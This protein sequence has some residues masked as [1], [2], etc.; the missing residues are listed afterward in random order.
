MYIINKKVNHKK[1][2]K[3]IV[4]SLDDGRFEIKF[5]NGEI[6]K[7]VYP[8]AFDKHLTFEDKQYQK[9]AE[10]E[11]SAAETARQQH[12]EEIASLVDYNRNGYINPEIG[13][14]PGYHPEFFTRVYPVSCSEV[15]NK[16]DSGIRCSVKGIHP[17][18][19]KIV[20]I[21]SLDK[22]GDK[23]LYKDHWDKK[24]YYIY[25][26][27]G[28]KGD[29]DLTGRNLTLHNCLNTSNK[30]YLYIKYNKQYYYQGVHNLVD[31]SERDGIDKKGN[32]RKEYNFKLE[33]ISA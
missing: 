29:Q 31:F 15:E 19:N 4:V 28:R 1:F 17:V 26:G 27:Q 25:Q 3:G 21:S 11:I 2:G 5:D 20:L 33:K 14:D 9:L 24:G 16:F 22:K 32:Q 7:F 30:I 18:D 13:F 10:T 8:D 6:K 23:Y 12:I